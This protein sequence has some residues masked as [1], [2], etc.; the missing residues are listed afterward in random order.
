VDG[1]RVGRSSDV[2]D[3]I[4]A[5]PGRPVTVTV[6][7]DG[8]RLDLV[9]VPIDV[10]RLAAPDRP[11]AASRPTG[12]VGI[13]LEPPLATTG[14]LSAVPR[15]ADRLGFLTVESVR[16]IGK[17]FSPAGLSRYVDQL[18]EKPGPARPTGDQPR[19]LSP[20]GLVDVAERATHHGWLDVL[21]LLIAINVFVG[22]FNLVPLPPLDGGLVALATYEKIR[23]LLARREY[24]ADYRKVLPVAAAVV[25]LLVF[26]G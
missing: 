20:K 6:E 16:G 3:H 18:T 4:R 8:R 1:R 11:V 19:F 25:A 2:V 24:R 12:F 23:S 15:A 22:V 9:V 21:S 10:S 13:G 17:V 26:I 5:R 14:P 7:R